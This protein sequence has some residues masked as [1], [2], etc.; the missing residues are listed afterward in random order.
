MKLLLVNP[1]IVDFRGSN[2]ISILDLS[3]YLRSSGFDVDICHSDDLPSGNYDIIGLS[4][5]SAFGGGSIEELRRVK[6]YYPSS[7]IIVGGKWSKSILPRDRDEIYSMGVE[8]VEQSG[9]LYFTGSEADYSNYPPWSYQ[10][11]VKI[12][13]NNYIMSAR[14]CPFKCHFCHNVESKIHYFSPHRTANIINIILGRYG[15]IFFVDDIFSLNVERMLSILIECDKKRVNIRGRNGFFVHVN[16][17][18]DNV[19]SMI[20]RYAPSNVQIGI[21]SGDDRMLAEM[22]KNTTSEKIRS[23]V[24]SM[25]KITRVCGLWLLGFPGETVESLENTYNLMSSLKG[26]VKENWFSFY[27]PIY[28]TVGYD[29]CLAEA[30][31]FLPSI[32]NRGVAYVPRALS[33]EIL[34]KYDDKMRRSK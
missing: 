13:G 9:E 23:A 16:V 19:L 12:C 4:C 7:K 3:A 30:G 26:V 10:D 17:I 5:I 24:T 11:V 2:P 21:E 22:G 6:N 8:V 25:S 34:L 14:G 31:Q 27:Q 18:N 33:K 28:N 29:K 1:N 20:K 32:S 15:S